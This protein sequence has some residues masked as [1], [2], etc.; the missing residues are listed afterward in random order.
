[1]DNAAETVL[2]SLLGG[3]FAFAWPATNDAAYKHGQAEKPV[4]IP[5]E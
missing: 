2:S 4:L 1:M 5:Q 3:L